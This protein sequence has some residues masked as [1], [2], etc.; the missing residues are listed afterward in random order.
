[1]AN[2][3]HALGETYRKVTS[4][5]IKAGQT[6]KPGMLV[7]EESDGVLIVHA[8]PGG[9]A[10]RQVVVEDALRGKTL[11]DAATAGELANTII[12]APG[13]RS[14]VL[15]EAG[16]NY[17]FG[18]EL[19]SAGDGTFEAQAASGVTLCELKEACDLSDS[20]AVDTLALVQW[21]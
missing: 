9:M 18:A 13:N 2:T 10:H 16:T 3:I 8:T 1:M 21:Y 19:Q 20:D 17:A 11:N 5:A 6:F 15:L 12:E 14:Q 7:E 4:M